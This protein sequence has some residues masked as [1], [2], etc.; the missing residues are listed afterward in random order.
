MPSPRTGYILFLDLIVL[1]LS[2]AGVYRVAARASVPFDYS[3]DNDSILVSHLNNAGEDRVTLVSFDGHA[4]RRSSELETLLNFKSVG[5]N[6]SV[7]FRTNDN[8]FEQT[9]TLDR[10]YSA[11]YLVIECFAALIFFL[12]GLVVFVRLPLVPPA[13]IFHHLCVAIAGTIVFTTGRFTIS[14]SWLSPAVEFAHYLSYVL[15][16]ILFVSFTLTFPRVRFERL[17]RIL[18]PTLLIAGA[19]ILIFSTLQL[20]RLLSSSDPTTVLTT[21]D[22]AANGMRLFFA[23]LF[24]LGIA[25]L[26]ISYRSAQIQ[27][28]RKQ[29]RWVFFG[30]CIGA[31]SF[32]VLW[33]IPLIF[34][35][36]VMVS[37]E[38]VLLLSI[39][40]PASF[41]IAIVRYKAFDIDLI[42]KRT[43]IYTVV[44]ALVVGL[45]VAIVTIVTQVLYNT[46]G[47]TSVPSVI[48]TLAVALAFEPLRRRT[49]RTID[50][51]FF[52]PEFDHHVAERE[53]SE[54]VKSFYELQGLAE[55]VIN[56]V[57]RYMPVTR[58][59]FFVLQ[60]PNDR[61]RLV[62]H[63]GFELLESRSVSFSSVHLKTDLSLPVIRNVLVV[64]D[65][66]YESADDSVFSRWGIAAAF[67]MKQERKV[68]SG[69]LVV[70][71][72]RSDKRFSNDDIEFL[73]TVAL[74]SSIAI[75]RV[76]LHEQL[77]IEQEE[78]ERLAELNR[79][80]TY[81]VSSVSHDLKTPL[82]SISMFAELLRT[83]DAL[84][85]A[86][87]HE[88]LDII[89]GESRRLSRL[90]SSVLDFA[91]IERGSKEYHFQNIEL[92]EL[93]AH[94][95][96]L[97]EY[98][99]K[100]SRFTHQLKL[101]EEPIS[102][103]GDRDALTDVFVN[104]LANS[105]KYSDARKDIRL[106]VTVEGSFAVASIQDLGIGISAEKL[107]RIFEAFF[108][109]DGTSSS[110]GAGLGLAIAKHTVDAHHGK[111][112]VESIVGEGSTF[113]V[114][115]PLLQ[116]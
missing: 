44:I 19:I 54:Q 100:M 53:I 81:F 12:I 45:Y 23:T 88:Y 24:F 95:N 26:F 103:L 13:R 108:R 106:S 8:A 86:K 112:E 9:I 59:G 29:L 85:P 20:F 35:D 105:M 2:V 38:L 36:R 68:V 58:I 27:D 65:A 17:R 42:I 56:E 22:L 113:K 115:L 15:T 74:Q 18:L 63:R 69:F 3:D 91:K 5:D 4:A 16:P 102:I 32:I 82:T 67:P 80:K 98:H 41:A 78:S 57:D 97:L 92:N 87:K 34:F 96:A 66:E 55:Y 99:F 70:G 71:A 109:V 114:Y 1:A 83:N 110:G 84:P 93:I 62:A 107:P 52:R 89:E 60:Q 49:Q 10:F 6:V 104:L 48:A 50:T 72:R 75:E 14:P 7:R 37:E 31:L 33:Q 51:W 90:I 94:V 76:R 79:L 77:I 28:E 39:V 43:T 25:F 40:A 64:P 61:L 11:R 47:D 73:K 111:I 21:Y 30:I 116:S 101:S 46:T